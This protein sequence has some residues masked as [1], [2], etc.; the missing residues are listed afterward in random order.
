MHGHSVHSAVCYTLFHWQ[1]LRDGQ[2][3]S[4]IICPAKLI[5]IRFIPSPVVS[6]SKTVYKASSGTDECGGAISGGGI[7][8]ISTFSDSD[9]IFDLKYK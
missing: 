4:N 6:T 7:A 2:M 9:V 8:S 5:L 3:Q 1:I